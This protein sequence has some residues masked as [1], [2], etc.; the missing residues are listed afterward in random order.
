MS[1][2]ILHYEK[3]KFEAQK[4]YP[5]KS[6]AAGYLLLVFFGLLGAHR[7]YYGYKGTAITQL[8]LTLLSLVTFGITGIA[9]GI[10]LLIDIYFVYQ[11]NEA[12]NRQA[13]AK[14]FEYLESVLSSEGN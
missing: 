8:V 12:H 6:L 7:F 11:Y 5:E 4:L 3:Q 10:W 2:A 9:V 14:Q 1:K 13:K